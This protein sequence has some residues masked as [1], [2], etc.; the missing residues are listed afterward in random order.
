MKVVLDDDNNTQVEIEEDTI[1]STV[2]L[3]NEA[4]I[5]MAAKQAK[6]RQMD[7]SFECVETTRKMSIDDF[8][9]YSI[10]FERPLSQKKGE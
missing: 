9:K 8:F 10:S 4:L 5:N 7:V 1:H 3:S 2:K 6:G